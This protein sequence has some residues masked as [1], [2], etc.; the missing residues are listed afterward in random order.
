MIFWII[1]AV[2]IGFLILKFILKP[3]FKIVALVVLAAV[4]WWLFHSYF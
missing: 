2:V 1:G 4:V 3:I